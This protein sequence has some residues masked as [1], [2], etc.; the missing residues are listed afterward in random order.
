MRRR[1]FLLL[2]TLLLAMAVGILMLNWYQQ[3]VQNRYQASAFLKTQV[4]F[5]ELNSAV[6]HTIHHF[7]QHTAEELIN[8]DIPLEEVGFQQNLSHWS[9][10]TVAEGSMLM[11]TLV[12]TDEPDSQGFELLLKVKEQNLSERPW[13]LF[14]PEQWGIPS[15]LEVAQE[16]QALLQWE[17]RPFWLPENPDSTRYDQILENVAMIALEGATMV[18]THDNGSISQFVLPLSGY[19]VR[20]LQSENTEETLVIK[21]VFESLIPQTL[22]IQTDGSLSL[23]IE[24]SSG[25][26]ENQPRLFIDTG[27]T[28][29]LSS[30]DESSSRGGV[31]GYFRVRGKTCVR[32]DGILEEVYWK[33]SLICN[34]PPAQS[35]KLLIKHHPFTGSVPAG[36]TRQYL[37]ANGVRLLEE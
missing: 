13:F 23:H 19:N 1:G 36:F 8:G 9:T 31:S 10:S 27:K 4:F 12:S 30:V 35:G 18:I 15:M 2:V 3:A 28:L 21:S 11:I 37:H 26:P 33:G 20:V 29:T 24:G 22:L 14:H 17:Q 7:R 32:F 16:S 25:F 34:Y 5:Q 6:L